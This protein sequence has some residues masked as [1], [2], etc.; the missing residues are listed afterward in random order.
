MTEKMRKFLNKIG[1]IPREEIFYIGGADVLPA[2]LKGQEEND[3]LAALD[4]I[5]HIARSV[6]MVNEG[7]RRYE[8]FFTA[9]GL[10]YVP[11]HTNFILVN[12]G[13]GVEVFRKALARGVIMR[14]MAAYGLT[15]YIRITIG[16]ERENTRC[17]EVLEAILD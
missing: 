2:P 6:Q 1:L 3:A 9:R 14:P 16:N 15:A 8:E 5:G 12:V 17:L 13:N 4:D 10:E 11:S 7:R